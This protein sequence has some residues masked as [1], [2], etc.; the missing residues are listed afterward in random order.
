MSDNTNNSSTDAVPAAEGKKNTTSN[1]Q[2]TVKYQPNRLYFRPDTAEIIKVVEHEAAAFEAHGYEMCKVVDDLHLANMAV[3]KCV[4]RYSMVMD[5]RDP[6]VLA[7]AKKDYEKAHQELKKAQAAVQ[8]VLAQVEPLAKMAT[9]GSSIV[10]LIP[11]SSARIGTQANP[12]GNRQ[13]GKKTTFVI[14]KRIN[15]I[16]P[17]ISLQGGPP[18]AP[19]APGSSTPQENLLTRDADGK[20]KID[21]QKLKTQLKDIKPEFKGSIW[22]PDEVSG[23]LF[24]WAESL[25]KKLVYEN[26]WVKDNFHNNVELGAQAQLMRYAAGAGA[27]ASWDPKAGKVGM[28]VEGK[29]E[30]NLA[31][32][33]AALVVYAPHRIGWVLKFTN[34]TG[35]VYPLGSI[36]ARIEAILAGVV[37]ASIILEGAVEVEAKGLK[38]FRYRGVPVPDGTPPPPLDPNEG[39]NITQSS[40]KVTPAKVEVGAFAGA[41]ADAELNGAL[42]WLN[43]ENAK[44]EFEDF[45][46][47]APGVSAMAGLGAAL[48]FEVTYENGKFAVIA[49]ASLCFG[50][51]ARGKIAFETNPFLIIRFFF[52]LFYQLHNS[53]YECLT[54]VTRPAFEAFQNIQFLSIQTGKKVSEF[55]FAEVAELEGTVQVVLKLLEK[56]EE[57][58]A[59]AKRILNEPAMLR[60]STPETKGMLLY[61]LTRHSKADWVDTGNYVLGDAYHL[62]KKAVLTILRWVQTRHE[63][64]NVLQHM[65]PQGR[66]TDLDTRR[67][68]AEFLQKGVM[69]MDDDMMELER[70]LKPEPARGYRVVANNTMDYNMRNFDSPQFAMASVESLSSIDVSNM[71]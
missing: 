41:K 27:E 44:K 9:G 40:L 19:P 13:L 69:D 57:R 59:F 55:M 31:E 42:Q 54:F 53:N 5:S 18:E 56:S 51:G 8:V 49:A 67:T 71:A 35:K 46:K 11:L 17:K 34:P 24:E 1:S 50:L 37:G 6:T 58:N 28:K 65:S 16:W 61:Q 43:P 60:I 7:G 26:Q 25:N 10:E 30:F 23:I 29:A 38:G 33:K 14:S 66:K 45:V 48:K 4:T 62:R 47:V 68:V 2:V 15:S 39:P 12:S 20:R 52:W 63:W 21:V 3:S 32:G 22:K 70:R 36:R 64:E